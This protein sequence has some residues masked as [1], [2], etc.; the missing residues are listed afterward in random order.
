MESRKTRHRKKR[1]PRFGEFTLIFV[2]NEHED[3]LQVR[4]HIAP[5]VFG[6]CLFAL[7]TVGT[8]VMATNRLK[9]AADPDFSRQTEASLELVSAE[10][11][12]LMR[13]AD[14]FSRTVEQTVAQFGSP[15]QYA[16][17][18]GS[19]MNDIILSDNPDDL[20]KIAEQIERARDSVVNVERLF[21]LNEQLLQHI[22]NAWPLPNN[23][24]I[25]TMEYGPNIH[26][27][28]RQVY[29]HKGFD[30]AEPRPGAPILA[31][32]DG[33]IE[34]T[35]NAVDYG[36]HIWVRHRFGFRT[37]YAH[38]NSIRVNEGDRVR[39]GDTI[40]TLGSSGLSTGPHLHL[41]LWMENQ[42][43]DPAPFLAISNDFPRRTRRR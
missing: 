28:T 36:L 22:P 37:L 9:P 14:T 15:V 32:A 30:I 24:G 43:L 41:E 3:P 40:G 13:S 27:F 12:S 11:A 34:K 29:L 17:A 18:A 31:V 21:S 25:V 38:L 33:V 4:I 2:P 8:A 39:Q 20:P 35:G 42:L 16:A 1:K 6:I 26:P 19:G 7:L 23:R 10:I 5:L